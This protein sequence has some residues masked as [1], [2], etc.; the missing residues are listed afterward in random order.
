MI[1]HC[2]IDPDPASPNHYNPLAT[3]LGG[4]DGGTYESVAVDNRNP[5]RPVFYVTEDL[6]DGA[7]RRV[8]VNGSGWDSLH[9]DAVETSFLRIL[10]ETNFEWTDD[11]KDARKSAEDYF[12]NA[13]G[14]SF[15]E[16]E[17]R[18]YFM[19]KETKRLLVLD[20]ESLTYEYETTGFKFYG[21]GSFNDQPDQGLF[22]G[23]RYRH[24]F[25]TEDGGSTPG[26]YARLGS[27]GTYYTVFQ[28]LSSEY[29]G[30]ETSGIALSPDG[31][32]LYAAFQE[33]GLLFEF[34][35]DDGLP[36]E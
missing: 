26:V 30:D 4:E 15:H 21:D 3:N 17:G 35:R 16:E 29:D 27:T 12:P 11:E 10:D 2:Q 34:T 33:A 24:M 1:L 5:E 20:L 13:E 14:I 9:T 8:V 31:T 28:G 18:V 6:D 25:F 36:F 19:S 32:R 7:L 22:F 23:P